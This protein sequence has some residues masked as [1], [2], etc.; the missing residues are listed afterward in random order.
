M[1]TFMLMLE[2]SSSEQLLERLRRAEPSA[3][4]E[5]YDAHSGAMRAFTTRMVGDPVVADDLVH[6]VFAKLPRAIGGFRQESSLRTFLLGIA[7]NHARQH[8]RNAVRRRGVIA[9]AAQEPAPAA[10]SNPEE[11]LRRRQLATLLT[12]ALH[13]LSVE[14]RTAFVLCEVEQR[15]SREAATIERVPEA[16]VRTRLH[17]AKKRL[18]KHLDGITR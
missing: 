1:T 11:H 7:A 12:N 5:V 2:N 10:P 18:R 9:L 17:H 6:E 13:K 14:Q 16:T 8:V 4:R 15:T 3:V